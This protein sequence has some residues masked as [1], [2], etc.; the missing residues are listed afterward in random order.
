MTKPTTLT[1][2]QNTNTA[3]AQTRE[4]LNMNINFGQRVDELREHQYGPGSNTHGSNSSGTCQL[5][6][7][8]S[9]AMARSATLTG[10][11]P[12]DSLCRALDRS[13]RADFK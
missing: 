10:N 13:H 1:T 2:T 7:V 3:A 8:F 5:H 12:T 4:L 11:A 9:R 6:T